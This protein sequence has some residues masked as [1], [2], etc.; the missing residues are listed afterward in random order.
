MDYDDQ[1]KEIKKALYKWDKYFVNP[2]MMACIVFIGLVLFKVIDLE[3]LET[4]GWHII[5]TLG[6]LL[7]LILI[8]N[9]ARLKW[10][11]WAYENVRNIHRLKERAIQKGILSEKESF[12]DNLLLATKEDKLR[13][14]E[15]EKKFEIEDEYVDSSLPEETVITKDMRHH[16]V[17]IFFQIALIIFCIYWFINWAE[18]DV[19]III[20]LI[21]VSFLWNTILKLIKYKRGIQHMNFNNRG[22][23]INQNLFYSWHDI[24]DMRVKESNIRFK[25]YSGV[26]SFS[27]KDQIIDIP[28]SDFLMTS[29]EIDKRIS[30]YQSRWRKETQEK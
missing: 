1:Q 5:L 12:F 14:Q 29:A 16:F 23:S 26:L 11:L 8:T 2:T 9:L 17:H 30:I 24:K 20:A 27:V 28:L 3:N 18:R 6:I 4:S 21:A 7:L 10:K 15:L 13:L 22:I 25:K 19:G